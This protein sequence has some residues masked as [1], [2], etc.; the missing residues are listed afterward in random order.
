VILSLGN[1]LRGDDGVGP[2]VREMLAHDSRLPHNVA[3]VDGGT[4]GMETAL[5]LQGHQRAIIV[6]AADMGCAP[7][8]W[9]RFSRE[10]V[11]LEPAELAMR[12]TLHSAGL[13]EALALGEAL[14][15]LPQEIVLYGVQPQVIDWT[16]G[17]S[18]PVRAAVPAV[19]ASILE[20]I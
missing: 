5:L 14:G 3:I 16:P 13:A 17:L 4:A 11:M 20:E 12:S 19:C 7:G 1:P 9:A 18:A 10:E 6:D 8:E 15:I 2:A